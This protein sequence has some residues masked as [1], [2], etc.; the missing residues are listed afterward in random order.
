MAKIFDLE[1][2][3]WRFMGKVFDMAVLTVLWFVTSIPLVTIGASTTALY[4]VCLKQSQDQEGYI[5]REF[6]HSFRENF[7][8]STKVWLIL[9]GIGLFLAGDLWW[10]YQF[11]EG[12]GVMIFFMFLVLTVVYGMI[13]LYVFPI[14]ARCE[15]TIRRL[16]LMAFVMSVKNFGWTLLIATTAV[17]IVALGLFVCAPLL[18]LSAG[19]I[20]YIHGKI[21]NLIFRQ[22]HLVLA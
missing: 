9:A 21:F 16:F 14:L 19:A 6:F 20:G 3:V 8:E 18:I 13:L 1:N 5:V 7:K 12:V 2:P 10:Y 11:K 17:C 15:V 4:Y 22:Y